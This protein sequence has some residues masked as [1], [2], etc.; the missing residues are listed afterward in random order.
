MDEP[1]YEIEPPTKPD[2]DTLLKQSE[3][4]HQDKDPLDM[5]V[6]EKKGKTIYIAREGNKIHCVV[7][8]E[9]EELA[10][11]E[12]TFDQ[13]AALWMQLKPGIENIVVT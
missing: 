4:I 13:F 1:A 2:G 8:T 9:K 12:F 11:H 3:P 7:R 6:V 5:L 10:F